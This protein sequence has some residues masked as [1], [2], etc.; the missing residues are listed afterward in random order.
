MIS[1]SDK[2]TFSDFMEIMYNKIY[3]EFLSECS[4]ETF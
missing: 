1:L 4:S 3:R 2:S